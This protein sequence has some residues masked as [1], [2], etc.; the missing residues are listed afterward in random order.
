M[1][2][3]NVH[4][5]ADGK[6]FLYIMYIEKL[7]LQPESADM[8]GSEVVLRWYVDNEHD[9]SKNF[10]LAAG[11]IRSNYCSFLVLTIPDLQNRSKQL[12]LSLG[13]PAGDH[14]GVAFLD[15]ANFSKEDV[16][17]VEKCELRNQAGVVA[18]ADLHT[19]CQQRWSYAGPLQIRADG[20]FV[21]AS[22]D[23]QAKM[24]H[25]HI[26]Q[27][28]GGDTAA[29]DQAAAQQAAEERER[30][31]R[32]KKEE[33]EAQRRAEEEARR[34]AEEER[35]KKQAEEAAASSAAAR[36]AEEEAAEVRRVKEAEETRR[37]EEEETR[38]KKEAED[39]HAREEEA[40][41][42][43]RER[44]R[45]EEEEDH[46]K[47]R[48]REQE[49]EREK[50]RERERR[51]RDEEEE[52]D[53]RE[54][55]GSR[56]RQESNERRDRQRR[57]D[58]EDAERRRRD[59]RDTQNSTTSKPSDLMDG[60]A[61]E[62]RQWEEDRERLKRDARREREREVAER[63]RRAEERRRAVEA[64]TNARL[65][66]AEASAAETGPAS[67]LAT[68]HR[69]RHSASTSS[70]GREHTGSRGGAGSRR[71][72]T[73]AHRNGTPTRQ[74]KAGPR[75]SHSSHHGQHSRHAGQH[76]KVSGGQVKNLQHQPSW[77]RSSQET[78]INS[79]S[80]ASEPNHFEE[81][82]GRDAE[83]APADADDDEDHAMHSQTGS[84]RWPR[85]GGSSSAVPSRSG[86]AGPTGRTKRPPTGGPVIGSRLG[87]GGAGTMHQASEVSLAAR[88]EN[89]RAHAQISS[90]MAGNSGSEDVL[91]DSSDGLVPLLES[92]SMTPLEALRNRPL[93]GGLN[94]SFVS[95]Q[96]SHHNTPRRKSAHTRRNSQIDSETAARRAAAGNG[97]LA[98]A[99]ADATAGS[100]A[101]ALG[102]LPVS[103]VEESVLRLLVLQKELNMSS[104]EEP[105]RAV[106]ADA[107][108][109]LAPQM[110]QVLGAAKSVC[111]ANRAKLQAYSEAQHLDMDRSEYLRTQMSAL[112]KLQSQYASLAHD[113]SAN[114]GLIPPTHC[115]QCNSVFMADALFCRRCGLKR[116]PAPPEALAGGHMVS[117]RSRLATQNVRTVTPRGG[118]FSHAFGTP[119]STFP[120]FQGGGSAASNSP[121]G[122]GRRSHYFAGEP[123]FSGQDA[124]RQPV[125]PGAPGPQLPMLRAGGST[126][127]KAKFRQ[128]HMHAQAPEVVSGCLS[129]GGGA[130][131]CFPNPSPR[132]EQSSAW[133][134]T[135]A[136][137]HSPPRSGLGAVS[138]HTAAARVPAIPHWE[139]RADLSAHG[140]DGIS[141][142]W[143]AVAA[144]VT[145][146]HGVHPQPSTAA[147]AAMWNAVAQNLGRSPRHELAQHQHTQPATAA[148]GAMWDAVHQNLGRSPRQ[149]AQHHQ[150]PP[151][152]SAVQQLSGLVDE[153]KNPASVRRG[154]GG[155]GAHAA[156][157]SPSPERGLHQEHPGP[158]PAQNTQEDKYLKI[159]QSLQ[160][161]GAVNGG[162]AAQLLEKQAGNRLRQVSARRAASRQV[163][164]S[165][166]DSSEDSASLRWRSRR[167]AA[168]A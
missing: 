155:G 19:A 64:L 17:K 88:L 82:W 3:P 53:R 46:R 100:I 156:A 107:T 144:A 31:D 71:T 89:L 20:Y 84:F 6:T 9:C 147:S 4:F 133:G 126:P 7:E 59:E 131:P 41:H 95:A 146:E 12:T 128:Q 29:A 81:E 114:A 113:T 69:A 23:A 116:E 13:N 62:R 28:T 50:D 98:A 18:I 130:G 117:P 154:R 153:L 14:I 134:M 73:S 33:A 76:A 11:E 143:D 49:E 145:R 152:H 40:A 140:L 103:A 127:P 58:D 63:E 160:A 30:E 67:R 36:R 54:R 85:M 122:T 141:P 51:R 83:L 150:P 142:N 45:K 8:A 66:S 115:P 43:E 137:L 47:R 44:R 70:L 77:G 10:F 21:V 119:G 68:E 118:P 167:R 35:Q 124:V 101:G 61:R 105:T 158:K 148:S 42:L 136:R 65:A 75:E 163:I 27:E 129:V 149:L 22:D 96:R 80:E 86:S 91:V 57:L 112:D 87:H 55:S 104:G 123:S 34:K 39:K 157:G 16:F 78:G 120:N 109:G 151:M 72:P 93:E 132:S 56:R 26:C 32:R 1:A 60:R 102:S 159:L 52:R 165:D 38:R 25:D 92:S 106:L 37:R 99:M 162:L 108:A 90:R 97:V 111:E 74:G 2:D 161:K 164:S 24:L 166:S 48:E 5:D 135:S 15:L 139:R 121:P 125:D 79:E 138:Y 110:L 94:S 168:A